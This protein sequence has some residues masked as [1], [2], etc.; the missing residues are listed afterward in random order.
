MR[1]QASKSGVTLRFESAGNLPLVQVDGA[2][3]ERVVANLVRN[4]IEHT[5]IGGQIQVSLDRDSAWLV[6]SVRDEGEGFD[7]SQVEQIWQR[8]YR[9][10]EA[11]T[12]HQAS[13]G[14]GLGLS[15]VK[16][17]VEAH[18]GRAEATSAQGVGSEF[19]VR[20]PV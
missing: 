1:P 5:P 19:T 17:F 11:R 18:G 13:D 15:I 8:F 4:A 9:V 20:L 16:G 12:R 14:V 3:I 10:D 2:R 6:L 7:E